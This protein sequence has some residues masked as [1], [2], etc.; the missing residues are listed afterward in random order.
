VKVTT[1]HNITIMRW[2]FSFLLLVATAV[3]QAVSSSGNKLLVVLEELADKSKYSR[4]LSN[5]EG[6]Y[7][8]FDISGLSIGLL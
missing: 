6:M 4:Y 5:L 8:L 2:I 7:A 1:P 3:V